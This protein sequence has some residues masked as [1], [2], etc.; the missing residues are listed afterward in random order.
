LMVLFENVHVFNCRS[1]VRSVFQHNPLRNPILLIGTATAQLVHIGAMYT[2]WISEVL[3]IQ[4]ISLEHW[5]E[6]LGLALSV[7]VVMEFHK[8][9]RRRFVK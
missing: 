3:H 4:P 5:L 9:I 7:L 1:E 8:A 6:L 2:P